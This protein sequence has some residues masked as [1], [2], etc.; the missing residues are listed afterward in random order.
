MAKA[1]TRKRAAPVADRAPKPQQPATVTN[2]DI[3]RRA[4]DLYLARG[5]EHGRDVE[6]WLLAERT[7]VSASRSTVA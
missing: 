1:T 4:Y 5:C 2:H 3:A 6:D 7:P